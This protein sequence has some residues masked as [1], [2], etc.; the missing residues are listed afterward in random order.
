M[1]TSYAYATSRVRVQE[2]HL[3][4]RGRWNRLYESSLAEGMKMLTEIGYG[5]DA[6]DSGDLETMIDTEL[7]KTR[8]FIHEITPDPALTALLLLPVDAHNIKVILKGQL[9]RIDTENLLQE[10]GGIVLDVLKDALEHGDYSSLPETFRTVLKKLEDE[11]DPR[12]ISAAVDSAVYDE[13]RRVLSKH[14]NALFSTY[15]QA[16][17]DFTNILTVLRAN[18]LK[19]ENYTVRPLLLQGG[20][21]ETG[22]LLEGVGMADEQLTRQFAHGRHSLQ[23]RTVLEH[24]A[25]NRNLT[26]VEQRFQ[27]MA[28]AIIHEARNDSFGIGPLANYYMARQAEAGALRVLFAGKRAGVEIPF[29]DLGIMM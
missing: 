9:E 27:E 21:L 20:E 19:W 4:D 5:G 3:I 15:F 14:K 22:T 7:V 6:A 23:I 28:F 1:A 8:Q 29:G 26:E 18:V 25:Q 13:V 24:Y 17:I 12:S 16:K 10:G 2:S 11:E